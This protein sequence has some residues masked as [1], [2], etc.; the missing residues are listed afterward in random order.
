MNNFLLCKGSLNSRDSE[1]LMPIEYSP[2][3]SLDI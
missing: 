1:E 3:L 2:E